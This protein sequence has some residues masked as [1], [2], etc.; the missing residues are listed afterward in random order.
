MSVIPRDISNQFQLQ[1]QQNR[2]L[3][4]ACL[5]YFQRR[6]RIALS[7]QIA[8]ARPDINEADS[9]PEP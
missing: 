9:V 5:F 6:K 4:V 1:S 3:M 7:F 8:V 2:V